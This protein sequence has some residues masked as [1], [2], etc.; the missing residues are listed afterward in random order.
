MFRNRA[1]SGHVAWR[2]NDVSDASSAR[3]VSQ[4][5][6]PSVKSYLAA[7]SDGM[8][9]RVQFG[10]FALSR[11]GIGGDRPSYRATWIKEVAIAQ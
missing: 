5:L 8:L 10:S 1:I 2:E 7:C 3:I 11:L 6:H 9:G 4:K